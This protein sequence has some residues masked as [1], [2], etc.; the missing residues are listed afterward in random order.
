MVFN[1]WFE[2]QK[3]EGYRWILDGTAGA[4]DFITGL[5]VRIGVKTVK[6]AVPPRIDYTAQITAQHA[7]EPIE[8]FFF[9]TYEIDKKKMWLLGGLDKETFLKEAVYYKAGDKVHANYT[10]REGHEI[11]NIQISKLVTPS[12]WL[13]LVTQ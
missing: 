2:H 6:R 11:F 12:E 5:N 7:N 13:K 8:Q 1:K 3:V 9:M 10:V 4:P